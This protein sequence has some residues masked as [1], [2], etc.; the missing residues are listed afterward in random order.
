MLH[1][2]SGEW[3]NVATH[4]AGH[5]GART[6]GA[7]VALPSDPKAREIQA[8]VCEASDAR[9][10]TYVL[11]PNYNLA[12]RGSF[13]HGSETWRTLVPGALIVNA[14]DT[15][16]RRHSRRFACSGFQPDR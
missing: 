2:K 10:F 13:S 5:I 16:E 12:H 9:V 11:T 3:L 8:I 15:S 1:K 14:P 7:G 6:C 4:F